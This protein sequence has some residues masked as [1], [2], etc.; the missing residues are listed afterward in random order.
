M[1]AR[2]QEVQLRSRLRNNVV[3]NEWVIIG[4]HRNKP[5]TFIFGHALVAFALLWPGL[6]ILIEFMR[7]GSNSV[8]V[9]KAISDF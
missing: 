1:S 7:I 9:L 3:G 5:N 4:W 2:K 6:A 8:P